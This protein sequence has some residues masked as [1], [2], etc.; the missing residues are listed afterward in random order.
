[1]LYYYF[2]DLAKIFDEFIFICIRY[3]FPHQ[4]QISANFNDTLFEDWYRGTGFMPPIFFRYKTKHYIAFRQ[5]DALL[6]TVLIF[7]EQR[8]FIEKC[9]E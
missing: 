5:K 1:M 7:S 2:L 9:S 6:Q 4:K 8:W 3:Q